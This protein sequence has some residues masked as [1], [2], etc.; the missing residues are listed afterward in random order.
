[1]FYESYLRMIKLGK[2]P[3]GPKTNVFDLRALIIMIN[4]STYLSHSL[5]L[6]AFDIY[7]CTG[8]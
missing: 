8:G 7:M 4:K 5:L 1:M 6:L 2:T 3:I